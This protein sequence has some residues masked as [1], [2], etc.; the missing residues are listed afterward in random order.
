LPG[1]APPNTPTKKKVL[2]LT[3]SPD[4]FALR[5]SAWLP[6]VERVRAW[7]PSGQQQQ[8][9]GKKSATAKGKRGK[10]LKAKKEL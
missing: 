2:S 4:N 10:Q 8:E 6:H 1:L 5:G 9:D 3:E 7:Q